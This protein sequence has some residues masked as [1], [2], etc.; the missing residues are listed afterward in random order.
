MRGRIIACILLLCLPGWAA[1]SG[2]WLDIPFVHQPPEGCG[3]ASI[4]MIIAYWRGQGYRAEDQVAEVADIQ[5]ALFSPQDHGIKASLVRDYFEKHGFRTF[6]LRGDRGLVAHH[7]A[8]GRPLMVTLKPGGSAPLHYLV[9]AGF[10]PADDVIL[11][12]DPAQRK[13]LKLSLRDFERE[14]QAAGNW[15][16][17]AVPQSDPR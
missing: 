12:N 10:E 9:I 16:L 11:V 17:L 8:R 14:W 7:L 15:T 5:Q 6:I 3:A 2:T 1:G 13:L 4:A